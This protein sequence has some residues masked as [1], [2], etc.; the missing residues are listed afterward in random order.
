M[1]VGWRDV[2]LVV[3][4][5]CSVLLAIVVV[6]DVILEH[7]IDWC[8]KLPLLLTASRKKWSIA[9]AAAILVGKL[10]VSPPYYIISVRMFV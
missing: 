8:R 7:I 3:F 6:V 5:L 4:M 9:L 10:K 1:F 2:I